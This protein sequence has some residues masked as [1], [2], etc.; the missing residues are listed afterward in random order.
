MTLKQKIA[1]YEAALNSLANWSLLEKDFSITDDNGDSA[2]WARNLLQKANPGMID[3][4]TE[5]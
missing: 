4:K 5:H 2:R 3:G 1:L